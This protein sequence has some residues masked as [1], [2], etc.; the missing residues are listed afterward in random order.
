MCIAPKWTLSVPEPCNVQKQGNALVP[1]EGWSRYMQERAKHANCANQCSLPLPP[2]C[3]KE[4][5]EWLTGLY[6]SLQF[7]IHWDLLTPGLEIWEQPY[8]PLSPSR[9]AW[10]PG[11]K[12]L[13]NNLNWALPPGKGWCIST[14]AQT[15]ENV[16]QQASRPE[17]HLEEQENGRFIDQTVLESFRIGVHRIQVFLLRFFF[18][19]I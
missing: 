6:S 7:G 11:S 17:D 4:G 8:F 16:L 14:Q 18:S 3:I 2:T 9:Q 13:T 10:P 5:S 19:V 1:Q 15:H 12:D